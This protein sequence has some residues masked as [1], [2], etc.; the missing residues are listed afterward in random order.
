LGKYVAGSTYARKEVYRESLFA[1]VAG[2]QRETFE[3]GRD[4]LKEKIREK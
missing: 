2:R 3:G 4:R 1:K